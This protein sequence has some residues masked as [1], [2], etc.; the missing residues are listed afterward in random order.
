MGRESSRVG[1]LSQCT[2]HFLFETSKR[3]CA[4]HGGK[5][6]MFRR[7]GPQVCGP[8]AAGGGKLVLP[9]GSQGRK[10]ATLGVIRARGSPGYRQRRFSLPLAFL[11]GTIERQRIQTQGPFDFPPRRPPRRTRGT[12]PGKMSGPAR[13]GRR[14][15]GLAGTV[16]ENP[17]QRGGTKMPKRDKTLFSLDR[18]RPVSLLA[19][20]K[21]NG[22]ADAPL[23]GGGAGGP[24]LHAH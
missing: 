18:A 3:K 15:T 11:P 2:P 13:A 8:P 7:V 12:R 4:V 14:L 6:K 10:R 16:S 21:R 1:G 20:Q 24:G 17:R 9:R 22:G 5:E 23:S 19:R